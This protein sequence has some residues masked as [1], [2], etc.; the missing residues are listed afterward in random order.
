ML[1]LSRAIAR[2]RKSYYDA[3]QEAQR[4]HEITPWLIY[5]VSTGLVAQTDAEPQVLFTVGFTKFFD[6]FKNTLNA[7]Q[8]RTVR[9]LAEAGPDGFEGGINARK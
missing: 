1:S 4:S 6:R 5:F 3:L 2:H 9:R 8:L 7:R